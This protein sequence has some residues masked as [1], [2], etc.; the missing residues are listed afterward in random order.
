MS[1][2]F[3]LKQ[4]YTSKPIDV[5]NTLNKTCLSISNILIYKVFLSIG[6]NNTDFFFS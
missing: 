4:K 6:N 2:K 5:I 1:E 3:Y